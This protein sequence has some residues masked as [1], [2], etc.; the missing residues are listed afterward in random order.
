MKSK[1]LA[2]LLVLSLVAACIAGCGND[3]S[4]QNVSENKSDRSEEDADSDDKGYSP[5]EPGEDDREYPFPF[6]L[7]F[8]TD[9]ALNAYTSYSSVTAHDDN[10]SVK[11][12]ITCEEETLTDLKFDALEFVDFDELTGDPTFNETL[13]GEVDELTPNKP[14]V[15]QLTFGEF[16]ATAGFS[17]VDSEGNTHMIGITESGLNGNPIPGNLYKQPLQHG[18]SDD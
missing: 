7:E 16:I 13:V 18:E 8:V 4:N 15:F 9:E 14:V 6:R 10:Y 17:Y 1:L 2:I 11:I 12:L 5:K 3:N